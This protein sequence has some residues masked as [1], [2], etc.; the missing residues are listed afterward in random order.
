MAL[1]GMYERT[2]QNKLAS[3]LLD[4]MVKKFK[5]SCKV[6]RFIVS[7]IIVYNIHKLLIFV[8][9]YIIAIVF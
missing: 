7:V 1:L 6:L 3:E 5:H 2:E 4:K 8:S 9:R